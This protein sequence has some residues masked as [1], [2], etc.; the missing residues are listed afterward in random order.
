MWFMPPSKM[1]MEL[2]IPGMNVLGNIVSV[3]S[4]EE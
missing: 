4:W 3:T 1:E 2:K